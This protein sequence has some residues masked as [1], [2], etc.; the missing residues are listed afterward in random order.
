MNVYRFRSMEYLFGDEYQELEKQTIYFASPDELND[1][2]EGFRDIVWRGDKIVWENLFKNYI[3]YLL[4]LFYKFRTEGDT[5][6]LSVD[7]IKLP[8]RWDREYDS[9][10]AENFKHVWK[11]FLKLPN[12]LEIIEA[13]ANTSHELRYREL[14]LLLRL[15]HPALLPE[16]E[17]TLREHGL[18]LYSIMNP[19]PPEELPAAQEL[20]ELTL[21]SIVR[22]KEADSVEEINDVLREVES[23]EAERMSN[24]PPIHLQVKSP[25]PT[26]ILWKNIQL[27]Q[28]FPRVYVNGLERLLFPAWYT[29]CF[30]KSYHNASMW[31]NYGDGHKG[32][33]LIF[34]S[35][36]IDAPH[37]LFPDLLSVQAKAIQGSD[38]SYEAEPVKI[39]FFTSL[40]PKVDNLCTLMK[41]WYTDEE[42][43]RSECAPHIQPDGVEDQ[44][45]EQRWGK[46]YHDITIK[47]NDW[48][49]EEEYRITL[50][51]LGDF[52]KKKES[53]TLKYN[54]NL[55]KGIIFGMRASDED[56]LRVIHIIRDKV[57]QTR[58]DHFELYQ[59]YYSPEHRDIRK[60]SL[61]PRFE[62][63]TH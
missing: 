54:F 12:V 49:Y 45:F 6:K 58:R 8:G 33:C 24:S 59:A 61:P 29:A 32:A 60:G 18:V 62:R 43:N 17:K 52:G 37:S 15:I 56:I 9:T 25:V 26:G 46:F 34:D 47:T 4:E 5:K 50:R 16:I 30:S 57:W 42:G 44:W 7:D 3:S 53:R 14:E 51:E 23:W 48:E 38:I 41:L 63:L 31:A 35:A 20:S 40:A 19:C 22:L 13:L 10:P 21:E 1:P 36:I 2:I 27:V 11:A 28:N 55:L 39:D